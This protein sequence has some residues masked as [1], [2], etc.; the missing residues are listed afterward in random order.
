[1]TRILRDVVDVLEQAKIPLCPHQRSDD[2]GFIEEL[3]RQNPGL[4]LTGG[5]SRCRKELEEARDVKCRVCVA[6]GAV[7]DGKWIVVKGQRYST[8][9]ERKK[10][11]C[12]DRCEVGAAVDSAGRS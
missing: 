3:F 12:G 9:L 11:S 4:R 8:V 1:M 2:E 5:W 6:R 10:D 7:A